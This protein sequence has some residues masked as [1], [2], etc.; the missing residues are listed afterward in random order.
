MFQGG[1]GA[2]TRGYNIGALHGI[3][4]W[5]CAASGSG[6]FVPPGGMKTTAGGCNM[7]MDQLQAGR[8]TNLREGLGLA[9]PGSRNIR[10]TQGNN[11]HPSIPPDQNLGTELLEKAER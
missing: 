2:A 10:N 4:L 7:R 3:R 1:I 6:K 9:T 5:D 8:G 11:T